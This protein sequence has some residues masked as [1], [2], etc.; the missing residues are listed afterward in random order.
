MSGKTVQLFYALLIVLFV[1][2]CKHEP[3]FNE[4]LKGSLNAEVNPFGRAPL[5][6]RIRLRTSQPAQ[7]EITV[8][9]SIP[10]T[11]EISGF[12]EVHSLPVLG[13][14]PGT[15]NKVVLKLQLEDGTSVSD[16]IR[17]RTQPLP[18]YFPD[19]EVAKA[20]RSEMEPGF[21]AVE[22]LV[23]NK[24]KFL[25]YTILFDDE[26]QVRWYMDM[27]EAGQIVYSSMRGENGNWLYLSWIDLWELSDLGETIK[28]EQFWNYSGTHEI[29]DMGDGKIM[30]GGSR[31][32]TK[33][34]RADG[35]TPSTRYDHVVL[36]DRNANKGM[37]HWDLGEV[38]DIDRSV[39]PE[40][41]ALDFKADW[42][43][44]NSVA[45]DQDGSVLASGRNQGVVKVDENNKP[46]WIMAPHYKW[47]RAGRDGT[48]IDTKDY[49]L[50]AID[51]NGEPY[52][53]NIQLGLAGAEDF[54]WSTGQHSITVLEN[55][56]YL[57]FDNG[58]SR[59]FA[60]KPSYSRAVEYQVDEENKTIR[61]VW[62]Y[63]K[64][65]GLDMYSHITSEVD[66]LPA[67]GNLLI[68]AGNIRA[69]SDKPHAKLVEITYPDSKVVFEAKVYFK[70][71]LGSG[72][73][74]WAQFDLVFRG[75]R[76]PL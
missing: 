31:K 60:E 45:V 48:G 17:M 21:N 64:E 46:I 42:F 74:A 37:K 28:R 35:E 70:D 49:L 32:D 20:E 41:F 27:S 73:R 52:E 47:G 23:G 29:I 59:D 19:I 72:E 62:Q 66:V 13:L 67:T 44:I 76:M 39:F 55:G 50:T 53:E 9:G 61:Q 1:V 40:D 14:Y 68:T 11:K 33:V 30:F 65:R 54:E 75:E 5:A 71:M 63:G 43:H 69:S 26:G 22:Y 6:G 34:K 10:Y 24:G 38:L 16:T 12:N 51:D 7:A 2:S 58:L 56:N 57:L 3:T 18:E 36:W 25:S 8:L 15:N 4:V